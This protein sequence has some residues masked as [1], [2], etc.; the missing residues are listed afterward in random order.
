MLAYAARK[1]LF[2]VPT[3][4]FVAL[5]VF[6][7]VRAIPGNPAQL[8]LGDNQDPEA[9]ARISAAMGLDRPIW[10]QFFIWF[11]DVIR[12]DFGRSIVTGEPVLAT[13]LDRFALTA[14]LVVAVL[15]L[16]LAIAV[17]LGLIAARRQGGAIDI[18]I[19][20]LAV[21]C[22]SAPAFWVGLLLI[23]LFSVELQWLPVVGFTAPG[24]DFGAALAFLVLPAATLTLSQLGPMIRLVRAATIDVLSQDY[25]VN[26]R[27]KGLSERA[28]LYRHVLK[29]AFPPVLSLLGVTL[30][31]MLGGAA[32]VETVFTL[33]GL[34]R[35][36]VESV[37]GRDYPV[38]QG[39]ALFTAC[40][41]ILV[42]LAVDLLYPLVDPKV[43]LA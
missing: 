26:A 13:I 8:M 1:L 19:G 31:Q 25:V 17:P 12:L 40:T 7:L 37:Q 30:G 14:L 9:L 41:Y 32:V 27:S 20:A 28:I 4:L 33:P 6:V 29:N 38:I 5:A 11:G 42:N 36:L 34:G 35:L 3:F 23:L 24:D 15:I 16:T 2:A 21:V 18:A 43:R 22:I 39:V 10:E